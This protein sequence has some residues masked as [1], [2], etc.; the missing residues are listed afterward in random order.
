MIPEFEIENG[1]LKKYHG[2]GRNVIIPE[3]VTSI[4]KGAF[5]RCTGLTDVSFPES[6]TSIGNGAFEYCT[7]LT[8]ISFPEGVETI[9]DCA[10]G[11]C[12]ELTSVILPQT[13]REINWMAFVGCTA[14]T[15]VTLPE[16]LTFIGEWAFGECSALKEINIP[17]TVTDIYDNTFVDCIRLTNLTL[18]E[19]IRFVYDTAFSGC[20]NLMLHYR[21][22]SFKANSSVSAD[23]IL[24][25]LK[26]QDF[27]GVSLTKDAPLLFNLALSSPE[28]DNFKAYLRE[29][30]EEM[31]FS[32]IDRQD[33]L[34]IRQ[35]LGTFIT[36]QNIN[37]LIQYAIEQKAYDIQ[38]LLTDYKYQHFHFNQNHLKL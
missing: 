22:Y 21:G 14:L 25:M 26:Y 13:V 19:N 36:E 3:G 2:D 18:P 31:L 32:L 8:G 37:A 6:V 29:H 4:G 23:R 24:T 9:G 16:G 15:A 38:I 12:T 30:S 1:V 20:K 5:S 34:T 27:F 33:I 35:V 11:C 10:F 28:E 17:E 7:G